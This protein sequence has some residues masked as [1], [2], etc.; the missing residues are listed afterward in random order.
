MP[1]DLS[2]SFVGESRS[3]FL[4]GI[5]NFDLDFFPPFKSHLHRLD[6]KILQMRIQ[7][8]YKNDVESGFGF[9]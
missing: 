2:L 4:I 3:R 7:N 6:L 1:I 9:E 8:A 5:E